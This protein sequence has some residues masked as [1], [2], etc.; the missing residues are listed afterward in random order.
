MQ[1]LFSIANNDFQ[2]DNNCGRKLVLPYRAVAV[3]QW[4]KT[5]AL[6]KGIVVGQSQIGFPS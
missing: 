3:T 6:E 4:V 1:S 2:C 5:T